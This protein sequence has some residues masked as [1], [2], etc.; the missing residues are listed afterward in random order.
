MDF[1]EMYQTM[2]GSRRSSIVAIAVVA[3]AVITSV[4]QASTA[5]TG[6]VAELVSNTDTNGSDVQIPVRRSGDGHA[7]AWTSLVAYAGARGANAGGAYVGRRTDEGWKVTPYWPDTDLV[8][9][10]MTSLVGVWS[11]PS[12]LS[13]GL[14][15]TPGAF[16]RE[17][18]DYLQGSFGANDV[19]RFSPDGAVDWVSRPLGS[20]PGFGD[21]YLVGA[22]EDGTTAFFTDPDPMAP[23]VPPGMA[24]LYR[25]RNGAVEAVGR[26]ASGALLGG[27][28]SLGNGTSEAIATGSGQ[29][30]QL[31]DSAAVS[32]DGSRFVY[33]ETAGMSQIYLHDDATGVTQ[34]SLSRRTGSVG[35]PAPTGALLVGTTPDLSK[36]YFQSV[37]QLTD[38]APG[39]GGDYVYDVKSDELSFSNVD[40]SWGEG[41]VGGVGIRSGIVKISDD[42][43]YVY[44]LSTA[45]L[46]P[47]AQPNGRNLYLRHGSET[48][49]VAVLDPTD[50]DDQ[51][52]VLPLRAQS[53]YPKYTRSA[54]SKTGTRL[55][56]LSSASLAGFNTGGFLSVYLYDASTRDLRCLSC[57]ADGAPPKGA[58]GFG[59]GYDLLPQPAVPMSDDG[60]IVAFATDDALV[61]QD[62]N[63]TSDVY[64]YR[65]GTVTLISSGMSRF[66][67]TFAGLSPDGADLYLMTRD[68]LSGEDTNDG[69]VDLY[70]AR[71]GGRR[72]PGD[73][74]SG[75]CSGDGCQRPAVQ[76]AKAAVPASATF[77]GS[78]DLQSPM[79]HASRVR[80]Q[81][82]GTV[83]GASTSVKVRVPGK[84]TIRMSGAGLEPSQR[85]V[86]KGGTYRVSVRLSARAR[87][88][89]SRRHRLTVRVLVRFTPAQGD[90]SSAP[91]SLTFKQQ[92]TAAKQASRRVTT[93]SS[94][95]RKGH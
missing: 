41:Y 28:P 79:R 81:A 76:P 2:R 6:R 64:E 26:D 56:F 15:V 22:S 18:N 38:D 57:R 12:D 19:F 8:R 84:G 86:G 92:K 5:P 49:L 1:S 42:G 94:D 74:P 82:A 9:P 21:A 88:T 23:G 83:A 48:R 31:A 32:P 59:P 3:S 51:L 46:Q 10:G 54:I 89:L 45:A 27:S 25:W 7:I 93:L 66:P 77:S 58:A 78:G 67:T 20:D 13:F 69:F 60:N 63:S 55:A 44:F 61:A 71:I 53:S 34:L 17:D 11:F 85:S 75:L 90:P 80:I 65:D 73:A 29:T 30:G 36:I 95:A 4:G 87:R 40:N 24:Q 47:G 37:D 16:D 35:Q 62:I 70:D 39:G 33:Q 52:G 72:A 68:S 50:R 14:A 91:L 43:E